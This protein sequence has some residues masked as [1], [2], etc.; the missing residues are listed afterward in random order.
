MRLPLL[1]SLVAL[2]LSTSL[3]AFDAVVTIKKVDA[4][5]GVL[6]IHAN[7]QDRTVT[8]DKDVKVLGADGKPLPDGLKAK[9]LKEGAEVTITVERTDGGPII[10]AI[11]LGKPPASDAKETGRSSVGLKPLTEM[12]AADRYKG[13]DGGLYGG[14]RNEPPEA[15]LKA[16]RKETAK[17]EPLDADGKPA[18]DGTIALV[19][20]SMSNATQE[21]SLFKQ[22]AD[23][24]P[25]KSPRVTIVDCAQGGQA[26]AE[27]VDPR[28]KAWL[29]ADRRLEAARV[30]PKQVQVAW[31]KLANKQPTGDL[32]K[33]G[34]KLQKDTLAVLHNARERFP[35]LRVAYLGSRIY[36]GWATT[37]L[38]P[39]PYAYEGAFAVRWLI[40]DQVRGD[41]ELNYD[42]EKGAVKAPLL[43]WGPYFWADGTTPRK[44]DGLVWERKDLA[45]DGTHP[46]PSGRQKVAEMLLAFFKTDPLAGGWFGGK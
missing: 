16:A 27:W 13:E 11:R 12:T 31:V 28:G 10:K 42:A 26:M 2:T 35:N 38:N 5:K 19:S 21:F 14:G 44:A 43:L 37:P 8:I 3:W 4:E 33:H 18:R 40:R 22:L 30:S 41:A 24:D 6:S 29:E 7:G 15:H 45:G 23:K 17:I 25:K 32:E 39:E 34:Q 9:E 36:G 20:I 46:S 1:T